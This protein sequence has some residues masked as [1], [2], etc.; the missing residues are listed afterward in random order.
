[1]T[2]RCACQFYSRE[3]LQK[4]RAN[5]GVHGHCLKRDRYFLGT[6]LSRTRLPSIDAVW[7]EAG[8]Q[9]AFPTPG[10]ARPF[11]PLHICKRDLHPPE[12]QQGSGLGEL[13]EVLMKTRTLREGVPS[14][15]QAFFLCSTRERL[16]TQSPL[17]CQGRQSPGGYHLVSQGWA[18]G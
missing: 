5:V 6:A 1:M 8:C 10:R 13:M 14:I 3:I 18:E 11:V 2:T 9:A 7:G 17:S 12:S 16:P 15:S 4:L